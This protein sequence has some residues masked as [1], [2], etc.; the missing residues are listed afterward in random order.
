MSRLSGPVGMMTAST[1]ATVALALAV[2][3]VSAAAT[4]RAETPEPL[5]RTVLGNSN[6]ALSDGAR[7][8]QAGDYERGVELT[9]AGLGQPALERDRVAGLSNLCAGYVGLR[10][11]ELALVRCSQS[12]DLDPENWRAL[13]NRAAAWLGLGRP[14]AALADLHRALAINPDATVL[15]RT[16]EIALSSQKR[17]PAGERRDAD[18]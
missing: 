9:L 1:Q 3:V 6:P 8:L 17:R 18:G 13:N 15:Q 4:A 5:N 7:A 16:L 11:F 10:K 12:L 14:D 2:L